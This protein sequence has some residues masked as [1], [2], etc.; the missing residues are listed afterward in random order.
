LTTAPTIYE[1]AV[2]REK[3]LT[4]AEYRARRTYLI[5]N[6]STHGLLLQVDVRRA[7]L[8]GAWASVIV[9]AQAVIEATL[10]DLQTQD[11]RS[12][13]KDLFLGQEDLERVRCLRNELV[14]P[15]APGTKSL[16]WGVP[17]GDYAACHAALESDAKKAY[18]LMLEAIYANSEGKDEINDES[19]DASQETPSK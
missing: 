13:A 19:G 1:E 4:E 12:K 8:A 10:R 17:R 9:I 3:W 6:L 14:H 2:A 7:F 5:L 11:Y 18:E 15:Q 16:V